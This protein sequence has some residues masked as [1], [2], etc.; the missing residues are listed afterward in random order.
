MEFNDDECKFM[1]FNNKHFS[2][3]LIMKGKPLNQT[4]RER[5]LGIIITSNL[6]WNTQVFHAASKANTVLAML[7][8]TFK[9]WTIQTFR[10]LYIAFVRPHLEYAIVVWSPY[11]I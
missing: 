6:K 7:K 2:I 9:C 10:K 11:R 4:E 1:A 3:S 5:D 8:K